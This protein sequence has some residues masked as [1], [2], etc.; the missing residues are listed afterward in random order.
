MATATKPATETIHELARRYYAE[1]K[2]DE[3]AARQR[4]IA[5]VRHEPALVSEALNYCASMVV[6]SQVSSERAT[7]LRA[8]HANEDR[9]V[10]DGGRGLAARA[11]SN[12]MAYQ[13][14]VTHK[15]LA[16]ATKGEVQDAYDFHRTNRKTHGIRERWFGLIWQALKDD[17]QP[18]RR[19]LS[20]TDLRNLETRA[21]K[22]EERVR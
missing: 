18:V 5:K 13:L 6:G 1:A 10:S 20:E 7:L 8:G 21:R 15:P 2:G 11:S 3:S 9:G 16:E 12:L 22:E 4:W 17:K 19:Q 14:P